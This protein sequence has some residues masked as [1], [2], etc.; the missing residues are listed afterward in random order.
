MSSLGN[1]TYTVPY[2]AV[3]AFDRGGEL[4]I[5]NLVTLT[6]SLI[7]V[8]LRIYIANRENRSALSFYKDDFLCFAAAVRR[9]SSP[10]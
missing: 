7:S 6:V 8:G 1:G 9:P 4:L 5:V 10:P 2:A 3:S